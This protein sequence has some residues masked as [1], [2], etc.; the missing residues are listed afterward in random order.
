VEVMSVVGKCMSV[1]LPDITGAAEKGIMQQPNTFPL[2]K[3]FCNI[4]KC[5]F[6]NSSHKAWIICLVF[7]IEVTEITHI[8][9]LG[10]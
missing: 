1:Y 6:W 8:Q 4:L 7:L 9:N 2:I 3:K 10:T 5:T